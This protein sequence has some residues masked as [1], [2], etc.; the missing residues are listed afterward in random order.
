M[1]ISSG[2]FSAFFDEERVPQQW[3]PHNYRL[4]SRFGFSHPC[5][6]AQRDRPVEAE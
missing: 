1:C 2:T 5:D 3:L 4:V 6:L